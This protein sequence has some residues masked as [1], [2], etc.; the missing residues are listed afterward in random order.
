M[1]YAAP[2]ASQSHHKICTHTHKLTLQCPRQPAEFT[3]RFQI[4]SDV[5]ETWQS[6]V[7]LCISSLFPSS[8]LSASFSAS[9]VVAQTSTHTCLRS[10]F[11]S[12][13]LCQKK[14]WRATPARLVLGDSRPFPGQKI[15]LSF[16]CRWGRRHWRIKYRWL[17]FDLHSERFSG[18]V[19]HL[20]LANPAGNVILRFA[21]PHQQNKHNN[22]LKGWSGGGGGF[23]FVGGGGATS[24][25]IS[26]KVTN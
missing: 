9:S 18:G 19:L 5:T 24:Q 14:G 17:S 23:F 15:N 7:R 22:L 3:F 12:T 11:D 10:V 20:G 26:K 1:H 2:F 8:F 21:L 13:Q 16:R 4:P 25:G 6:Q